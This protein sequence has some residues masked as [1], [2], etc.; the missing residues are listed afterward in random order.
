MLH[1]SDVLL[2]GINEAVPIMA[3]PTEARVC[4]SIAAYDWR[5]VSFLL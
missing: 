3:K 1:L 5:K 4:W 2:A